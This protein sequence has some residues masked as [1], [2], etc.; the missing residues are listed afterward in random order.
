MLTCH[1][2]PVTSNVTF[3]GRCPCGYLLRGAESGRC[4]EC[5]RNFAVDGSAPLATYRERRRFDMSR[6]F[7]LYPNRIMLL[8]RH[9]FGNGGWESIRLDRIKLTTTTMKAIQASRYSDGDWVHFP[10]HE[11]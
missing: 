5:G 3:G 7:T 2:M 8:Q 10:E 11:A 4:P 1:A 6:D 9:R